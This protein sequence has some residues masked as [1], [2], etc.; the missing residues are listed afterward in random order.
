MKIRLLILSIL[1]ILTANMT[2]AQDIERQRPKEWEG[3]AGGGLF[4]DRFLPIPTIGKLSSDTW[5]AKAVK[6]RYT[7]N[8]IEEDEWSYW[9]GNIKQDEKGNYHLYVCRWREDSQK[10]H[11]EWPNSEVVHAIADNSMGP[12]KYKETIGKGH[13][14]EIYQIK[15]GRYVL[16]VNNGYYLS[17]TLNGP[18]KYNKFEF[19]QRNRPIFDHM[20]NFTF[21]QRE[22]DSY[23]MVCRGGG[24]WLSE[25]G[26]PPFYQ[27]SEKSVYPPYD[28]RY[29]DPVVWRTNIQYHMIVNDWLGRIAYYLRSKDGI[30]WKVE[31][32]EAYEPGIAKYEDGTK[33]DWYKFE[34]IKVLQD[35][36]GRAIQANFAVA[37]TIK[38]QDLGSDHHSSK[39]IGIPLTIGRLITVLDKEKIG[40]QTKLI[41]IK[42]EAE[43]GFNPHKDIN[44]KSLRFGA[45]EKVNYGGGSK[46]LKTKKSGD[47]LIITFNAAENGLNE[48]NFAAKLLGKT[49]KGKL[50]FA[51]ARLPWVNY[52]EQALSCRFP[53]LSLNGRELKIELEI[54]NFG[55]VSSS[56]S[57]VKIEFQKDGKWIELV[58]AKAPDLKPF[59]KQVLTLYAKKITEIG[60]T[61]QLRITINQ[62]EQKSVVLEGA[63]I[64][65]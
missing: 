1:A 7:D 49:R 52:K 16:Y 44:L 10:G 59:E 23:L 8:G 58:Q 36:Y 5:G 35:K 6:P 12:F 33:V 50:L 28:G 42:I 20:A 60:S 25:N 53:I 54:Q 11:M 4:I 15:D 41:R 43:E 29:E 56:L 57:D 61:T 55:Q 24:I 13:N 39:N 22:D 40:S 46:V 26:L 63:V 64:I 30:N 37:D 47:D 48:D 18:W 32:G 9:G 21:A 31:P 38:K 65:R 45:S 17:N 2:I 62:K 51:Y 19:D 34:R 3:L 27:V 14:P